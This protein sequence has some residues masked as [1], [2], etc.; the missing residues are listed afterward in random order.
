MRLLRLSSIWCTELRASTVTLLMVT[1][2]SARLYLFMFFCL[3]HPKKEMHYMIR[4][5]I[6][7]HSWLLV[8][9]FRTSDDLF[10]FTVKSVILCNNITNAIFNIQAEGFDNSQ[11][12]GVLCS[13]AMWKPNL[14]SS[15]LQHGV[16]IIQ[17]WC[18]KAPWTRPSFSW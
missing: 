3:H 14:V 7:F 4:Y 6:C 10:A 5:N 15:T 9:G 1:I 8:F 12:F 2:D 17:K 11:L 18:D 13:V 16:M